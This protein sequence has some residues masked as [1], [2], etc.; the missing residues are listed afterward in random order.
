MSYNFRVVF[1]IW[2]AICLLGCAGLYEDESSDG[3]EKKIKGDLVAVETLASSSEGDFNPSISADPDTD[4]TLKFT[5]GA[6]DIDGDGILETPS[7]DDI[8]FSSGDTLGLMASNDGE[9]DDRNLQCAPPREIG[10]GESKDLYDIGF[11]LDTTSS[12]GHAVDALAHKI[13][14][15]AVDLENSGV[16][17]RFA[18]ITFGDAFATKD[19]TEN[20]ESD[21]TDSVSQGPLGPPPSFDSCE[22]PST[23][24]AGGNTV[25]ASDMSD[26]FS[27]IAEVYT[28]GCGGRGDIENYL[29]ALNYLNDNVAWREGAVRVL[30][31]IGDQ[32]AYTDTTYTADRIEGVWIPPSGDDMAAALTGVATVHVIGAES[33]YYDY[34]SMKG[35]SD[36]TGGTFTPF[37]CD[38]TN[39]CNV[40]L[41]TLPIS[42]AIKQ[43]SIYNCNGLTDTFD[44]NGNYTFNINFSATSS[45]SAETY[46]ASMTLV[47]SLEF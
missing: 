7:I 31:S 43:S 22:R 15:F 45:S 3:G 11:S 37:D 5:V 2:A 6:V 10:M 14:N 28:S 29:G 20:T 9:I 47:L 16:D 19:A 46:R 25:I 39:D 4:G 35:I 26:F 40:D 18:G 17:I 42:M 21:F 38:S 41:D 36:A 24:V 12:M 1:I 13:S 23:F 34:Y 44:G 32:C 33:C 8:H 30:I 27:Q